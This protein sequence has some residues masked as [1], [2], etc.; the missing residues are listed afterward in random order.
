MPEIDIHLAEFREPG[1]CIPPGF[2]I[3][4]FRARQA[5]SGVEPSFLANAE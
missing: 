3:N 1:G 4:A 5:A 2:F